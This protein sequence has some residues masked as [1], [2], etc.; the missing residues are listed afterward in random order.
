MRPVGGVLYDCR[1]AAKPKH[2]Q[3]PSL[4]A[5]VLPLT[6]DCSRCL[7]AIRNANAPPEEVVVVDACE[8]PGPA[9]PGSTCAPCKRRHPALV[10]PR[11]GARDAFE[12]IR[13]APG[14]LELTPCSACTMTR[15]RRRHRFSFRN[16]LHHHVHQQA[17]GRA[18]TFWRPAPSAAT[19][20][21]MSG[22]DPSGTE[23]RRSRTSAGL[24]LARVGEIRLDPLCSAL[25]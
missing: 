21:S 25:T 10:T 6:P 18:T 5:V 14:L 19:R 3:R 20:S 7:E 23:R 13:R 2:D 11:A 17:A 24:R 8:L 22:F 12:R 9:P 16:L 4:S 1:C 15:P